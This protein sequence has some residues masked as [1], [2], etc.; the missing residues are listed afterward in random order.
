MVL[1]A[2]SL[3]VLFDR[4]SETQQSEAARLIREYV[5]SRGNPGEKYRIV[6][7]SSQ[8]N[9]IRKMHLGP[10]GNPPCPLCGR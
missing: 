8:R 2:D 7:E 5:R 3:L 1:D 4:L 6:R 10:A 9:E